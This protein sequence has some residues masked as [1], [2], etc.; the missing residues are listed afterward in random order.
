VLLVHLSLFFGHFVSCPSV[1]V[2]LSI[3][4]LVLLSLFLVTVLLIQQ[5]NGQKKR[6]E[7]QVTQWPKEKGQKDKQ[8]S[9]QKK[10]KKDK[11]HNGLVLLVLLSLFFGHFVACPSVPVLVAIVLL[12]LL[13]F[14]FGHCVAC[15]SV[16]FF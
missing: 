13:S 14:S 1:S 16:S 3:V 9:D 10:G 7:G 6:T 11:E 2:L 8:H 4:F 12:V 5:H 15:P